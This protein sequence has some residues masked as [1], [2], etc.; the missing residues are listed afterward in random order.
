MTNVRVLAGLALVLVSGL[1]R[2]ELSALVAIE[3][4][5][6]KEGLMVSRTGIESSLSKAVG[7]AVTV[8]TSDDLAD[9]MR[10]TRSGAHDLFIAPA[11][12]AASALAR[13]YELV[14]ATAPADQYVLVGRQRFA[15]TA[16]VRGNRIYLPQ[17]DSIYT[18]MARGM[19]NATGLSFKDLSN[20][21]Y[22]RYPQAGLTALRVGA[23]DAT[24]IRREDWADWDKENPGVAKVLAT[25]DDVPGGF[26]VVM[27]SDL[28]AD[29]RARIMKWFA[30]PGT[31]ANLRPVTERPDMQ[32][33]KTVAQLGTF[34]P[35]HLPGA[36]VVNAARVQQLL[37]DGAVLVDTRTDKEFRAKRVPN[38][39][40]VPYHEKS[41]KDTAYDVAADDFAGLAKLDK[42]TAT[43]FACN[44]A[45][46]WKSYKASRAALS[47]GFKR[48][49]WFRGGLPEWEKA[50]LLVAKE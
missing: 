24:V 32:A 36:E 47:A 49:Y 34:T 44:G 30:S 19:L 31:G 29:V 27:K 20:V 22:A 48:V 21:E 5:A 1:A 46:C 45:E 23:S 2:A 26:S 6:R 10:S 9:V 25:S 33:Y 37:S 11:Q 7:R 39:L 14:G 40:F 16:A 18:Y 4:T 17:Q 42:G 38:A 8:V 50:G 15:S 35:T 43:I 13:G 28:P 3:P 41:L 12:V